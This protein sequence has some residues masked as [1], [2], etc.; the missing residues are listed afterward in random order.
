MYNRIFLCAGILAFFI[1]SF[2]LAATQNNYSASLD[3]SSAQYWSIDDDDQTGLDL[4]SDFTISAWLKL[5]DLPPNGID[6]DFVGKDRQAVGEVGYLLRI[7]DVT[8]N[9]EI[10]YNNGPEQTTTHSVDTPSISDLDTWE[11]ITGSCSVSTSNCHLYVNGLE[12]STTQAGAAT[13]I[14]NNNQP[15]IIGSRSGAPVGTYYNGKIDD[16]RMWSRALSDSEVAALHDSPC[17]FDNGSNLEGWWQFEN[18]G[19]DSSGNGNTLTAINSPTFSSDTP[20][21]CPVPDTTPPTLTS[22]SISSNNASS[23]NTAVTGDVVTLSF[24]SDEPISL[25]TVSIDGRAASV[26]SSSPTTFAATTTIESGD[27]DTVA[28]SISF[29][30]LAGNVGSA[31]A[32]TTDESSVTVLAGATSS[33]ATS[34]PEASTTPSVSEN[35]EIHP[36]PQSGGS[37][38]FGSSPTA[39]GYQIQA[40]LQPLTLPTTT[41]IRAVTSSTVAAPETVANMQELGLGSSTFSSST[42]TP[43]PLV[44]NSIEKA[45]NSMPT[46]TAT[47]EENLAATAE[48]GISLPPWVWVL[49]A[50]LLAG[51]ALWLYRTSTTKSEN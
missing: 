1:P 5:A 22:V 7:D 37:Q 30:D 42:P 39:P 34:S 33:E 8:R 18:N 21:T 28:F 43:I 40:I 4:N 16:V 20:Y 24:E 32:T 31:I 36:A 6:Y 26:A 12:A 2:A 35:T 13:L 17:T 45:P 29:A 41:E 15:F 51:G 27:E 44:K 14:N 3:S 46:S 48:S 49:F 50:T 47:H 23:T 25:P 11:L 38:P 9:F 10:Y 19:S